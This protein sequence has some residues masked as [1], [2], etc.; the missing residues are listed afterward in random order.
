MS[1]TNMNSTIAEN[2]N[3][4]MYKYNFTFHD[5]F[6]PLNDILKKIECYVFKC[7]SI[8]DICTATAIR[9]F[10]HE[11]DTCTSNISDVHIQETKHIIDCLCID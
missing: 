1:F 2:V 5:W 4:F 9:E 8:V 7:S 10:C 6:G 11:R 3:F